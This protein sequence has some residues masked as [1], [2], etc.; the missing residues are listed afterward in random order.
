MGKEGPALLFLSSP[1][2]AALLEAWLEGLLLLLAR[3]GP[4]GDLNNALPQRVEGDES[5]ATKIKQ[6][7][8][9][10]SV[11][12]GRLRLRTAPE[13]STAASQTQ[14]ALQEAWA[15]SGAG[16]KRLGCYAADCA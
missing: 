7:Q 3:A 2:A 15:R 13:P 8:P 5:E 12:P 4:A 6:S 14:R 9:D 11:R 1:T 16:H 10:R